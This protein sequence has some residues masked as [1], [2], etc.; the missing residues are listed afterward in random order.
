M[1]NYTVDDYAFG[2]R[3]KSARQ[4]KRLVKNDFEKQLIQIDKRETV[5]WQAIR[6]LPLV[7]LEKPYQQGWVRFF[8]VRDDV[9]RSKDGLFFQGIL[10]KI[11]SYQY[12]NN[13]SFKS[14]KCRNRKK[15][16]VPRE[17]FLSKIPLHQW[18][19]N[20]FGLTEKEKSYFILTEKWSDCFKRYIVGYKFREPWRFVLRTRPHMVT[21]KKAIDEGLQSELARLENYIVNNNLRHKMTKINY[22]WVDKWYRREKNK[23]IHNPIH[24]KNLKALYE[25]YLDEKI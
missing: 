2:S 6:D 8:V 11:N 22:G 5:L 23:L 7:P 19:S 9:F 3:F 14:H 18:N 15:P 13:K 4:K 10:E 12:C 1:E 21:H 24:N 17:Q 20:E 16:Q 25:M